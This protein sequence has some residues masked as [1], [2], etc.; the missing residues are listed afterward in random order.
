MRISLIGLVVP[1]EMPSTPDGMGEQWIVF[2][3]SAPIFLPE[4]ASPTK[5]PFTRWFSEPSPGIRSSVSSSRVLSHFVAG[6]SI[7]GRSHG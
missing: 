2:H 7:P 1:S 6:V 4:A 5:K 3:F